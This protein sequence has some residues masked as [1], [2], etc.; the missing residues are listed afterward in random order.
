MTL[1]AVA[2]FR[3]AVETFQRDPVAGTGSLDVAFRKLMRGLLGTAY[4]I[5]PGAVLYR[6]RIMENRPEHVSEICAPPAELCKVG[7]ANRQGESIFYAA[8]ARSAV[9]FELRVLDGQT[10]SIGHWKLERKLPTIVLGHNQAIF[11]RY[12]SN[13]K[14][15]LAPMNYGFDG[16][17]QY[18]GDKLLAEIFCAS[19]S[20]AAHQCSSQ[21]AIIRSMKLDGGYLYGLLYPTMAMACN[22]DNIALSPRLARSRLRLE[23]VEFLRLDNWDGLTATIETL[24]VARRFV[25]GRICWEAERGLKLGPNEQ[26]R[27]FI[28]DGMYR[29]SRI[30]SDGSLAD[31]KTL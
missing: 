23:H 30:R 28:E 20:Q 22:A 12:K 21:L 16:G 24:A 3:E 7:R 18:A 26:V 2:R 11:E 5:A 17:P 4:T 19:S 8:T 25:G 29:Y 6:G 9:P 10:F 13:R 14:P 15:E 27:L 1:E 31:P